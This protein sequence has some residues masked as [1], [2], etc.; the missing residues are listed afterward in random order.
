VHQA[1][2]LASVE[3]EAS[4]TTPASAATAAPTAA[5]AGV[6]ESDGS[7][8]T[9]SGSWP[10]IAHLAQPTVTWAGHPG[11]GAWEAAADGGVFSRGSAPFYGSTGGRRLA[12]PIVGM[13]S[14]PSGHGYW[15]VAADG[16]VFSYGDAHF[17]G[18]T[19]GRQLARPIVAVAP[20]PTGHG[21]WLVASD[22]GVFSYGDAHFYGST[23]STRLAQ[24][25]VGMAS[26]PTGRGY[27]L[28]AADG[29]V[30]AF[31][32]A[33]YAGST[34]AAGT[35]E[36]AADSDGYDEVQS[37]GVVSEFRPG[38]RAVRT[39]I[40]IPAS[41]LQSTRQA[42]VAA[43]VVTVAMSEV[44]RPYVY[45]ASGPSSFDCSGLTQYAYAQAGVNLP[46]TAA[47]Q[48]AATPHVTAANLRPGD[49]VFFYPGITHVGV[50]L[51]NGLMV[52]APHAGAEVRV[53][54]MQWFGPLMGASAP[55]Q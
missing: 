1:L 20:T 41:E 55:A 17:Y 4:V 39:A 7:L 36:I 13:A 8:Y 22:G 53:E 28:A 16:G 25:I 42:A 31:G 23:G 6:V 12:E 40:R 14:T 50:Y 3:L 19:G 34:P 37:D 44:G 52:D 10:A 26:A 5:K 30:F 32:A 15:M 48:F 24:P 45:G 33:G 47:Q 2:Q 29:G 46:R 51:G 9:T 38:Q 54:S 11:G 35:T 27:W 49:L 21:Y 43:K 18:S